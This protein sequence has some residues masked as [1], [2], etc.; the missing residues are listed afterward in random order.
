MVN[1][2]ILF[3]FFY[4]VVV[5]WALWYLVASLASP[6]PWS[7][8]NHDYNTDDCY[9]PVEDRTPGNANSTSSAEEYWMRNVLAADQG[10]W[11]NFVRITCWLTVPRKQ[12]I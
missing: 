2:G 12:Q 5:S 8:C 3:S 10:S 9:S 1:V 4:I 6:L 11:D 7:T